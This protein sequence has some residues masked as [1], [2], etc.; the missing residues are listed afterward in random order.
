MDTMQQLSIMED[1]FRFE[2]KLTMDTD[3]SYQALHQ[4]AVLVVFQ[5]ALHFQLKVKE[6]ITLLIQTPNDYYLYEYLVKPY[7]HLTDDPELIAKKYGAMYLTFLSE[8][9]QGIENDKYIVDNM[10]N[11][12]EEIYEAKL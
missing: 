8:K 6:L 3:K 11:N 1:A 4:M 12:C 7:L 9:H 10:F 5:H 2:S